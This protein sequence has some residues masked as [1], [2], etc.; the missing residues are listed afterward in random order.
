MRRSREGRERW[1][2]WSRADQ[3]LDNHA[4]VHGE[5]AKRSAATYGYGS[6]RVR[7][8]V[9]PA[10]QPVGSRGTCEKLRN[11]DVVLEDGRVH[12][13]Q[14]DVVVNTTISHQMQAGTGAGWW[15]REE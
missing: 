9:A 10:I 5:C 13:S 4:Q 15:Q 8:K 11:R 14:A 2:R 3:R 12:P 6:P 1:S 7:G